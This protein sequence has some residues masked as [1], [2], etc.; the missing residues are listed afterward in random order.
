VYI[1]QVHIRQVHNQCDWHLPCTVIGT[2]H[3]HSATLAIY[4]NVTTSLQCVVSSPISYP[5]TWYHRPRSIRSWT[6]CFRISP[7][8]PS[9]PPSR[10][11]SSDATVHLRLC[12]TPPVRSHPRCLVTTL[13]LQPPLLLLPRPQPPLHH[14]HQ[15]RRLSSSTPTPPST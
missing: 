8:P 1:R 13:P 6:F 4:M 5:S 2:C 7:P 3:V 11:L 15:R 9:P 10:R 14:Y 12:A